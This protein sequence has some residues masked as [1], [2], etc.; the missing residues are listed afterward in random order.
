MLPCIV[1]SDNNIQGN[2][3]KMFDFAVSWDRE[4]GPTLEESAPNI[5]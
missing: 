1:K 2:E 4:E 5:L 3:V